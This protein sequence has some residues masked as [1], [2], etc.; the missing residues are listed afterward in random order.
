MPYAALLIGSNW[1]AGKEPGDASAD[2]SHEAVSAEANRRLGPCL[3]MHYFI[4]D[5][6]I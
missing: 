5:T 6:M 3:G 4:A 2:L 1:A